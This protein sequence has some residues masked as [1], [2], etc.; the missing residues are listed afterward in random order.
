MFA[1]TPAKRGRMTGLKLLS[2]EDAAQIQDSTQAFT[3]PREIGCVPVHCVH[4]CFHFGGFF[5][6]IPC[7]KPAYVM[8]CEIWR[9]ISPI[10]LKLSQFLLLKISRN[11]FS[12]HINSSKNAH[13]KAHSSAPC[14]HCSRRFRTWFGVEHFLAFTLTREHTHRGQALHVQVRQNVRLADSFYQAWGP[15][16]PGSGTSAARIGVPVRPGS[17]YQC[18]QD[19]G[20][21]VI[22]APRCISCGHIWTNM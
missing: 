10:S 5:V 2:Q 9:L 6:F 12:S 4:C 7:P 19:W 8:V 14:T 3:P 1:G 17:G 13:K 18:G 16:W 20:T 21:S 11:L 15:V 22:S